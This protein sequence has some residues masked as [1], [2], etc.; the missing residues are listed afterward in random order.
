MRL[1]LL[2]TSVLASIDLITNRVLELIRQHGFDNINSAQWALRQE[3]D[4]HFDGWIGAFTTLLAVLPWSISALAAA[5]NLL[6]PRGR[7]GGGA[8]VVW[9]LE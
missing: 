4:A 6:S 8:V 9:R 7:N 1:R 5:R 3:G 2:L